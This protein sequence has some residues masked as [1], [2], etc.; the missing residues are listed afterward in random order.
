MGSLHHLQLR[1]HQVII[2]Q[3]SW[4]LVTINLT[5]PSSLPLPCGRPLVSQDASLSGS[6]QSDAIKSKS[7]NPSSQKPMQPQAT[8]TVAKTSELCV[9][10]DPL[11]LRCH[12]VYKS[13]VIKP[14][15][16]RLQVRC[17]QLY[18]YPWARVDIYHLKFFATA[19]WPAPGCFL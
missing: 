1:C 4:A 19:S 9:L 3:E 15:P 14:A 6:I 2:S 16:C 11:P 5:T 18:K 7:T 12:Q 10:A 8:T 17:H 13:D